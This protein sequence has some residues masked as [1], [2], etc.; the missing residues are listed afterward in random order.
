MTR[1]AAKPIKY[2]LD[3]FKIGED[4]Y[5]VI[6]KGHHDIHEFMKAVRSNVAEDWPLGVP[7]HVWMKTMPSPRPE[8]SAWYSQV[9]PGTRGA[10]PCTLVLEAYHDDQ[11][12]AH[13]PGAK[14]GPA[15]LTN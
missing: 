6:S 15:S 13:F 5:C 2:P 8:F 3:P 1:A 10:W 4:T 11:Y 9:E 14:V 7:Q 12:E